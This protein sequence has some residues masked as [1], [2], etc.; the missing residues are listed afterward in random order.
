MKNCT[1]IHVLTVQDELLYSFLF[2]IWTRGDTVQKF[3]YKLYKV[4][5]YTVHSTLCTNCTEIHVQTVECEELY[6]SS[7]K[8]LTSR[9]TVQLF[10]SKL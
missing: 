5:N 10:M 8:N 7:S 4:K 2:T 6:S 3:M 1:V 9:I